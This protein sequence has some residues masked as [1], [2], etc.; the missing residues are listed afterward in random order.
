MVLL[1][2]SPGPRAEHHLR[3]YVGDRDHLGEQIRMI[4][5]AS[6]GRCRFLG[7]WHTHPRGRAAPSH[8]DTSTAAGMANEV[9]VQLPSLLL[10]IKATMP[11]LRSRVGLLS[12]FRWDQTKSSLEQWA[13]LIHV[14]DI[15][16]GSDRLRHLVET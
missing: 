2:T 13:I 9:E 14:I 7:T 3:S 12:A 4:Y 6:D 5:D 10:L 15:S 16:W 11:V 1:A 8:R